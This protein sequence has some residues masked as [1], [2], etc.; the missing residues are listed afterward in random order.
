MAS[1]HVFSAR[2]LIDASDHRQAL[3]HFFQAF[4]EKPSVVLRFW[5][6][7]IQ[8]LGGVLGLES[9]FLL[10]RRWRRKFQHRSARIIV[11]ETGAELVED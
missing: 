10:Y 6:K 1:L 11:G 9:L 5:Y 2:R 8:A 7:V 4:R 3:R